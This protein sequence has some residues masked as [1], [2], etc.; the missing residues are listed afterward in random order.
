MEIEMSIGAPTFAAFVYLTLIM[1]AVFII[2][3]V[4]NGIFLL[5]RKKYRFLW[6]N[7]IGSA[8]ASF[9]CF[10]GTTCFVMISM[11]WIDW[12]L[13]KSEILR[14]VIMMMDE[15]V[16]ITFTLWLVIL[17]FIWIFSIY[18]V[19]KHVLSKMKPSNSNY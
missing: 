4:L 14:F 3:A 13:E 18:L 5:F 7:L 12:F 6:L 1:G 15:Y 11:L 9:T 8:V 10:I 16:I 17:C 2:I 19:K